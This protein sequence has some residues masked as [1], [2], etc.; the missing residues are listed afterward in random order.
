[1]K[2]G[3]A[4]GKRSYPPTSRLASTSLTLRARAAPCI[5][6]RRFRSFKPRRRHVTSLH[7]GIRE[8]TYRRHRRAMRDVR[9]V[10]AALPELC[11]DPHRKRF[12]ARPTGVDGEDRYRGNL[13]HA[14]SITGSMLGLRTLRA[15]VPAEG[16]FHRGIDADAD[17]A[18][19]KS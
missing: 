17:A 15:G 10:P 9:T 3:V 2:P 19:A 4:R 13:E 16:A 18:R 7:Q 12:A 14:T 11:G 5:T 1:M 8:Y 6:V